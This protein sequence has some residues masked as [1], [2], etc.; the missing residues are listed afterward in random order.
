[1]AEKNGGRVF[2]QTLISKDEFKKILK[3]EDYSHHIVIETQSGEIINLTN[4]IL[5]VHIKHNGEI[6]H[7]QTSPDWLAGEIF[8]KIINVERKNEIKFYHK[9]DKLNAS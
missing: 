7:M 1:M 4:S 2:E 6:S 8:D 3:S 9:N 5:Q